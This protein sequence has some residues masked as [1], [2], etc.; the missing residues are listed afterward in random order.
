MANG[1]LCR[2]ALHAT[3]LASIAEINCHADHQPYHQA[4][5]CLPRKIRHQ[6]TG[7]QNPENRHKRDHGRPEWTLKVRVATADDPYAGT[8][9]HKGQQSSNIDHIA[10]QV[11]RQRSRQQ[12]YA[13]PHHKSGNPRRTELWMHNAEYLGQQSVARHGEKDAGLAQQHDHNRAAQSHERANFYHQASP[14]DAGLVDTHG[15][16]VAHVEEFV[17]HQAAQDANHKNVENRADNQ[18]SQNSNR[19]I[20]R[21][22]FGFLRRGGDSVKADISEKDD[23]RAAADTGPSILARDTRVWRHERMPIDLHQLGMVEQI[24]TA[25]RHKNNQDTNLDIDNRCIEIGRFLD[26]DDKN[27]SGDHDGEETEQV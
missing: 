17:I 6:V 1:N 9:D 14:A 16:C 24:M 2:S 5:P 21:R 7:N 13:G 15:K 23:S 27:Q 12:S 8:N 3:I 22:I 20:S 4:H 18:R 25:Y 10:E 26:A 11:N 19:H